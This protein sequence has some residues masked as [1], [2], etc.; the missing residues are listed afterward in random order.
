MT[1]SR[2][3]TMDLMMMTKQEFISMLEDYFIENLTREEAHDLTRQKGF[4]GYDCEIIKDHDYSLHTLKKGQVARNY[5]VLVK[6][7]KNIR[8][9]KDVVRK[10]T[11]EQFERI[12]TRIF[13]SISE[14][15]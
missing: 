7:P 9:Y 11:P 4:K 10:A 15:E 14:V 2:V 3:S 5:K 12:K 1:Y 13:Q 8:K 6:S